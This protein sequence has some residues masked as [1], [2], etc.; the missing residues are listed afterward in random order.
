M[1]GFGE[2]AADDDE[3]ESSEDDEPLDD[4][5]GRGVSWPSQYL[6]SRS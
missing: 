2:T 1:Y 4:D 6:S 3:E 5:V